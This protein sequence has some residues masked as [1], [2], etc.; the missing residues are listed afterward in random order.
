MGNCLK[1]IIGIENFPLIENSDS[2]MHLIESNKE[3]IQKLTENF[4]EYEEV[5]NKNLGA[6]SEDLIYLNKKLQSLETFNHQSSSKYGGNSSVSMQADED[7]PDLMSSDIS[8]YSSAR[9]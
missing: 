6:M 3:S 7:G 1:T 2:M 5:T 9:R 8:E 4:R